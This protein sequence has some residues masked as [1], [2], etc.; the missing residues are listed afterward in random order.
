MFP[1]D[2]GLEEVPRSKYGTTL[3]GPSTLMLLARSSVF[4]IIQRGKEQFYRKPQ[5]N[6]AA[7]KERVVPA[8]EALRTW[9]AEQYRDEERLRLKNG[10]VVR[11]SWG[12]DNSPVHSEPDLITDRVFMTV[13]Y[14]SE[15]ELEAMCEWRGEE[16]EG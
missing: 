10:E 13:L 8:D 12:R 15:K 2:E 1:Y 14:G 9:L 16:Y 6:A 5:S 4:D 7:K 11:F 3:L